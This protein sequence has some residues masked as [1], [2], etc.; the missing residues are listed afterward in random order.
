M[1]SLNFKKLA[2]SS[3]FLSAFFLL[4]SLGTSLAKQDNH[5]LEQNSILNTQPQN[6]HNIH[7]PE[8]GAKNLAEQIPVVKES[9]NNNHEFT[10]NTESETQKN[11]PIKPEL[12][13]GEKKV[14]EETEF[15]RLQSLRASIKGNRLSPEQKKEIMREYKKAILNFIQSK[16]E[17]RKFCP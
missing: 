13:I 16:K 15:N 12:C 17:I 2:V 1:K 14:N 8:D 5:N 10:E 6:N 4:V 11:E 3:V 9:Q 7:K